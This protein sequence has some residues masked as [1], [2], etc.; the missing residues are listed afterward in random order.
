[1]P[2]ELDRRESEEIYI[3]GG[4]ITV[5]VLSIRDNFV[6][7]SIA[8]PKEIAIDRPEIYHAKQRERRE[9]AAAEIDRRN[10]LVD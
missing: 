10:Q 9:A 5:K 3:D 1:M 2:L 7:L 8:A 4:L 6:R